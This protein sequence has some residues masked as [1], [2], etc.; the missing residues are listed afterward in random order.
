MLWLGLGTKTIWLGLGRPA[1]VTTN[2]AGNIWRS[3]QRYPSWKLFQNPLKKIASGFTLRNVE[4]LNMKSLVAPWLPP[5]MTV[6]A[7]AVESGC[8]SSTDKC[9]QGTY[10]ERLEMETWIPV[11]IESKSG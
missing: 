5:C 10:G 8:K 6:I 2:R 4:T 9:V 1:L 7:F 3:H 11:M